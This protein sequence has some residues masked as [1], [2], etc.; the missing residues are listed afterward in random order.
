MKRSLI[1]SVILLF[2]L[3]IFPESLFS[4]VS[5]LNL[6]DTLAK[7]SNLKQPV[8]TTSRL[9]GPK[10]IIDGKLDDNCWK[11]GTWA[12]DY[13]QFIPNEGALP[14]YP[15]ELNIQYDDRNLYVAFR[16]FDG[17]PEKM[18]RKAGVRDEFAG[19]I[20]GVTFDS[21]HDYRTGFEFSITS[22][23]QKID[24]ILFNPMNWDFNWN[25]V[26]KGKTGLEDSAWVAELEIPLS[27]L[28]Y[29]NEEEQVWGM[30]TW[31]WI[32][33]FQEESNWEKQSK[34]G[35]GMIYN[36]GELRGINGLKKSRRLEIMPF[37]LGVLKQWR[38]NWG[39][40]LQRMEETGGG[41]LV[42]MQRSESPAI[43]HLILP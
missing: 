37:A 21:Y 13:T 35:P 17:E 11:D 5:D 30:H 33:R 2:Y 43:L 14:S 10:P 38:K 42:L 28:R 27:Q 39:I 15:T 7:N 16:A 8:Y 32:D 41:I 1:F 25:A 3:F 4:A 19:D 31:R 24:L 23:G 22:W 40:H 34:T 26:W 12:G 36:F 18:L 6:Q 29:S 9:K 20:V